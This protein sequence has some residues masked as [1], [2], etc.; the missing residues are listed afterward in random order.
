M[1]RRTCCAPSTCGVFRPRSRPGRTGAVRL[2]RA[3]GRRAAMAFLD[4]ARLLM[5]G[6]LVG[7]RPCGGR[8]SCRAGRQRG[9]VRDLGDPIYPAVSSSIYAGN[10]REHLA[11]RDPV[12]FA[13]NSDMFS[14]VQRILEQLDRS[15]GVTLSDGGA[16][17]G[18]ARQ[19]EMARLAAEQAAAGS[20]DG[21]PM[22]IGAALPRHYIG[23]GDS[24]EEGIR[25]LARIDRKRLSVRDAE[26]L[27]ATAATRPDRC[28]MPDGACARSA[29]R[30]AAEPPLRSPGS[31]P[32]GGGKTITMRRS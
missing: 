6:T 18:A 32:P 7:R 11:W 31:T 26:L 29:H 21:S 19:D 8:S 16:D 23:A 24:Y 22:A 28:A 20:R 1:K 30:C 15:A 9:Q 10:F 2:D 25:D 12:S 17:G 14:R 27:E 3:P 5:P 13:Q 4:E